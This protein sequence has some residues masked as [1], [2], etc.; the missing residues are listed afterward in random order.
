[1]SIAG[2]KSSQGDEYQL[3]VALHWLIRLLED[4]SIQGIQV[5]STGIPGEDYSITV[6]DIVVLYQD[7]SALF[8]QAKKN[9]TDHKAWS[10]SDETLKKELINCRDQLESKQDSK[11]RLY[12]RTPFEDLQF[13]VEF[14]R[15]CTDYLAFAR[16]GAK[17]K[18]QK[19]ILKRLSGIFDRTEEATYNLAKKFDFG[20][21]LGFNEWDQYNFKDLDRIVPRAKL[22]ISVL[23]RYLDSHE[24]GLRV[25]EQVITREDVLRKLSE[26]GLT[27][28]P[29]RSEAEILE[30]FKA[31]SKIGREWLRTIDGEALPRKE[32][33]EIVNLIEEGNQ[34]ILVT[35]SAGSGKTCL[36]LDLAE[37]IENHSVW[38]LLFIKGDLFEE[39]GSEEDLAA[40]GLPKDLVG[41]CSRLAEVHR[42]VVI[43]D[44]LDVLSISRQHKPL[45]L[46]LGLMDRL[47][48]IDGV[49][50]VAACRTFDLEYDPLLRGRSW[51]CKVNLQPLDFDTVVYPFLRRWNIEPNEVTPELQKLLQ[52]P[53]NLSLYGKLAKQDVQLQPTSAYELC[54]CFL[55]E[56]IVKNSAW[57]EEAISALQNMADS[58]MEQR[59][60]QCSKTIFKA[61]EDI[62]R[63]LISQEVL[64]QPRSSPNSLKFSHQTLAD[65]LIVRSNLAAGRTLADFI[66]A[67]PQLPYI[68]PAV[69]TFFFFLRTQEFKI[70]R[71]Q[72]WQV[73][74]HDDIAYH[75]KRLICESFAEITP[76]DQ[77]WNLLRKIFQQHPDLFK[78][79]FWRLKSKVWFEL[80]NIYWLPEAKLAED[81]ESWLRDFVLHSREWANLYPADVVSLWRESLACQWAEK[82]NLLQIIQSNL[83]NYFKA[84]NTDGTRE[85]LE[86]LV[87]DLESQSSYLGNVLSKWICATNSGDDLLWRYI[88]KDFQDIAIE[89]LQYR[90]LNRKLR[91][92]ASDFRQENFLPSWSVKPCLFKAGI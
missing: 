8:I 3:R 40:R 13:L 79:L 88:T 6:D 86:I 25:P 27:P 81:K 18:K 32:L 48:S 10:L 20:S 14:C 78:R 73:I 44:S 76:Y 39:A 68:R 87:E 70:F 61:S 26:S 53:Q 23:E 36:L 30:N 46:F 31:A 91:C 17:N 37:H 54:N 24:T 19:S 49:T 29:K 71:Q 5:N 66:L 72:V 80:L 1:M 50:I 82:Q 42:V 34:K 47:A 43:L 92:S 65:C 2:K 38:K 83:A 89:D 84:W 33:E 7:G 9:Q 41:Q 57:G 4:D 77:D 12:S 62:V 16:E 90:D 60:H 35:D 69:R 64:L 51:E 15:D 59:T 28:T 85:L 22:A 75:V 52:L 67:H 11:V 63:Q 74:N 56:T 58:L 55:E 21:A 45:K